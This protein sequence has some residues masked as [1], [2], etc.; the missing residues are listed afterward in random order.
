MGFRNWVISHGGVYVPVDKNT[1]PSQYL[2]DIPDRDILTESGK[3]LTLLNSSYVMRQVNEFMAQSDAPLHGHIASL[4]PINP[5]NKPDSWET[6]A[7]QA[8]ERGEMEVSGIEEDDNGKSYYRFMQP[9]VTEKSCLKCHA[10]QGYQEGDIRGGVSVS[11]PTD[12]LLAIEHQ[13]TQTLLIGHGGI[14]LLGITGIF[15]GGRRQQKTLLSVKK[16]EGEVRLL[17]DSIAHAIYGQDEKGHCTFANAT[18]LKLL[19]YEHESELLGQDM[20]SLI[21]YRRADG[22]DYPESECPTHKTILEGKS[23]HIDEEVLW[24]KDGSSFPAAYWSYPIKH[25]KKTIGA[26]TTFLDISEQKR[27]GEAL[28]HSEK[29]LDTIVEHIPA[30]LFLKDAEELRFERFNQAGEKLLGYSQEQLI[31]KNDF[32]F[33]TPEQAE[34]FTAKDRSV[35]DSHEVLEVAEE[36]I[37]TADGKEKWLHTF[38]VGLYDEQEKP[39]HLLGISIDITAKKHAVEKLK[40]AQHNL[41]EA[42]RIAHIGSWEL[43]LVKN[44]LFW[45]DEIYRIFEIE[46]KTV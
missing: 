20:H 38:K 3:Q 5:I 11:I 35:F 26:V 46:K 30:M 12:A 8:F 7:L 19:G 22:S 24:R 14:W 36:P 29:L 4:K 13:E 37:K 32:D 33:F 17:T 40:T 6:N 44:T 10:H 41:A 27:M 25:G 23:F 15:F 16:S 39:T 28:K 31:G 42:Q 21:H 2:A 1:P 43:D 45:S 34:F 9:M 18:C